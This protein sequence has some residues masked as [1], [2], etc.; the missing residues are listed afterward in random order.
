MGGRAHDFDRSHVEREARGGRPGHPSVVG[1][2]EN[3]SASRTIATFHSRADVEADPVT[4]SLRFGLIPTSP[5]LWISVAPPCQRVSARKTERSSPVRRRPRR[6][7]AMNWS[8]I[9]TPSLNTRMT[10]SRRPEK[11]VADVKRTLSGALSKKS[12]PDQSELA[13]EEIETAMEAVRA[14]DEALDPPVS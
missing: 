13:L 6:H 10:A 12:D 1:A 11:L 3:C 4:L 2:A 7:G 14:R 8:R 9:E 5:T